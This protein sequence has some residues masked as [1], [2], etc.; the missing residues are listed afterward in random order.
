MEKQTL[1]NANAVFISFIA[2]VQFMKWWGVDDHSFAFWF[3]S[4]HDITY[5]ILYAIVV[6]FVSV[7]TRTSILDV[8]S[9]SFRAIFVFLFGKE[10]LNIMQ[11]G[12]AV[13][14]IIISVLI[15]AILINVF[16]EVITLSKDLTHRLYKTDYS[17][18]RDLIS[19]VFAFTVIG[20]F[21]GGKLIFDYLIWGKIK[22][23]T[24]VTVFGIKTYSQKLVI[25]ALFVLFNC[26]VEIF[27]AYSFAQNKIATKVNNTSIADKNGNVKLLELDNAQTQG[28]Q[29]QITSKENDK[30]RLLA[31]IALKEQSKK[32]LQ[33]QAAWGTKTSK[34]R[35]ANQIA[36][37]SKEIAVLNDNAV[38]LDKEINTLHSKTERVY[39]SVKTEN[40]ERKNTHKAEVEFWSYVG[41][42]QGISFGLIVFI[43]LTCLH[44]LDGS[45]IQYDFNSKM[46]S[47]EIGKAS[48][49]LQ[50]KTSL[51]LPK[52]PSVSLNFSNPFS[53]KK[54]K[55][56]APFKSSNIDNDVFGGQA[57]TAKPEP[58]VEVI[59]GEPVQQSI[60]T[61]LKN[62]KFRFIAADLC[63]YY[64]G[65]DGQGLGVKEYI[66]TL[67][68]AQHM[69]IG[70]KTV[71]E[72]K[73]F[74]NYN[75]VKPFQSANIKPK[76][77]E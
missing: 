73:N 20:V 54:E 6:L 55:E 74:F 35:A 26:A 53:V 64:N 2:V 40:L 4:I 18:H 65:K 5:C 13:L 76:Y 61:K 67:C 43:I 12:T 52:L 14:W 42:T 47:I 37:I 49:S 29:K 57:E 17:K 71:E 45:K 58:M 62:H 72:V 33:P 38:K 36:Q 46:Q 39:E 23:G 70:D 50:G 30:S 1:I 15:I 32:P 8:Q 41:Y 69:G 10:R 66:K 48:N 7:Y 9:A 34:E 22:T 31:L 28:Y 63:D 27:N 68:T 16:P 24:Q 3:T 51:N 19:Y 44:I 59:S 77:R 56:Q 75:I 25:I 11:A 60:V 21:L